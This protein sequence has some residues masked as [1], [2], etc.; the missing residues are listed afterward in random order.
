[1]DHKPFK[2]PLSPEG[3]AASPVTA[4]SLLTGLS[5]GL[6]GGSWDLVNP[7]FP[8]KGPLKEIDMGPKKGHVG[9][10][11]YTWGLMGLSNHVQLGL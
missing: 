1:M 9:M 11:L 2:G 5:S 4:V 10:F 3:Q 8:L 7:K 6:V